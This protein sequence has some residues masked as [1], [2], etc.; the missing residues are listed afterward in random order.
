MVFMGTHMN[1]NGHV[2]GLIV[3]RS[4]GGPSDN[5]KSIPLTFAKGA[6]G[7]NDLGDHDD[8]FALLVYYGRFMTCPRKR[9]ITT[10]VRVYIL[11]IVRLVTTSYPPSLLTYVYSFTP[12]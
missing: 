9:T 11:P 8:I 4:G 10:M 6:M 7:A 1:E 12:L 2:M 5:H 3:N